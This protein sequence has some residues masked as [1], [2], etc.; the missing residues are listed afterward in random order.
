MWLEVD[1]VHGQ[2]AHVQKAAGWEMGQ[3]MPRVSWDELSG[4][5]QDS[6]ILPVTS[7]QH[8]CYNHT[9]LNKKNLDTAG[10]WLFQKQQR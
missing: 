8:G 9:K 6:R 7:F 2:M 5:S 1:D 10:T 4:Q 3:E